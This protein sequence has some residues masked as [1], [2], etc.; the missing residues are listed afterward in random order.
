MTICGEIDL[1]TAPRLHSEL[2]AV[3]VSRIVEA[4]SVDPR[5]LVLHSDNGS[6]RRGSTMIS[7]LQW[8][9]VTVMEARPQ[10][11]LVSTQSGTEVHHTAEG[12]LFGIFNV[13]KLVVVWMARAERWRTVRALKDSLEQGR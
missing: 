2:G 6:P 1:Y 10:Y 13:M 5:G 3:L 11:E 9:G 12:R 8:L 4:G 7:T